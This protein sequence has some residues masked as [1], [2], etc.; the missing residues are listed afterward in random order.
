M[1]LLT[2]ENCRPLEMEDKVNLTL[3]INK[4]KRRVIPNN[5]EEEKMSKD[6]DF[7]HSPEFYPK[8][9]ETN[10]SILLLKQDEML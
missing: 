1:K 3:L 7:C 4:Q 5:Q 8:N 2:G 9:M 10:Y 6:M